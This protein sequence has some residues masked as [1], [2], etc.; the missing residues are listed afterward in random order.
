[1]RAFTVLALLLV[2][3]RG[4]ALA[5]PAEQIA[6]HA[7]GAAKQEALETLLAERG[8]PEV[9]ARAVDT[10]RRAGVGGQALLEARFLY[11][12]DRGDDA[13]LAALLPDFLSRQ[14]SFRL[15]DSVIFSVEEEWLSVIEYLRALDALRLGDKAAFKKHITEAFWLNPGHAAAYAPHIDALRM[16]EA[17]AAVRIGF[18]I[19]LARLGGGDAVDLGA[20]A[21]EG[22]ALVLHFWSPW[23]RGCVEAMPDFI[24]T[25]E[26]LAAHGIAVVSVVDGGMPGLVEEA[27][28]LARPHFGKPRGAWL[29]DSAD[30]PLARKLR[31]R[32]FPTMVIV[33]AQGEVLF[34]GNASQEEFWTIMRRM[35]ARITRPA[36]TDASPR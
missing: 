15:G 23:S 12:V 19:R 30:A 33:S 6:E 26:V 8:P 31:V 10:A 29:V 28:E 20:L 4:M 5:S 21:N 16:R 22:K 2:L 18:P 24:A 17:M 25:A 35:D 36:S 1:M 34:N 14:E 11:Q 3:P 32:A 27:V 13:A 7:A 9:F